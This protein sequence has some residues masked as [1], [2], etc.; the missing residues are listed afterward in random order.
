VWP[1]GTGYPASRVDDDDP[2]VY[3]MRDLNQ[4]P[5]RIISEI[6]TAGKPG[7]ITRHGRFV[8]MI[9]P[10]A[11]GQVESRVLAEMAREIGERTAG[12]PATGLAPVRAG[13]ADQGALP[14]RSGREP[15][16][17]QRL[18]IGCG[19]TSA[20]ARR[21]G[22]RTRLER[23]LDGGGD[24]PRGLRADDD[25]PAEQNA[26]DDLP[27]MRGRAVRADGGGLGHTRTVEET[28]VL[29]RLP[30]TLGLQRLLRRSSGGACPVRG[31]FAD[32]CRQPFDLQHTG[33]AG[34]SAQDH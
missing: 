28:T 14:S 12:R 9:T 29:V 11:A 13:A 24:E 8:A 2:L 1:A 33:Q 7:F 31:S 25:V 6:E 5:A 19:N 10:L 4:E 23:G 17:E 20:L 21:P 32:P 34:S 15:L 27:G 16:S 18:A 3:T 22:R 30:D 26:A